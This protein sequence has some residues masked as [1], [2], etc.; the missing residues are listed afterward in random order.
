MYARLLEPP[1]GSFFLLGAR[2]TGK[3]TWLHGAFPEATRVDL[4]DEVRF[5][6][7]LADPAAFGRELAALPKGSRVVVDEIQRLPQLLNEVHRQIEARKHRFALTGSSARKLRRAGVNLLGG[8]AVHRTMHPLVP[9]ELGAD[10]DLERALRHGTLPIVWTADDP[11]DTLEAY[12]RLYLRE[13]IQN[14]ALVRNL[15]S[16]ARFLPFAALLHG[17]S[18]NVSNLA[19]DAGVART[20][21]VDYL[22]LLEDTL[23]ATRLEGFEAR[24]RVRERKHAKLYFVDPGVARALRGRLGK[25]SEEER[26]PLFEGMVYGI[27]R[28]YRGLGRLDAESITYWAPAD[29]Q[30]TEVDFLVSREGEHV[31]IE[32]KAS[33]VFRQEHT[34]GLRAI[35][36]LEGLRR[37]ILVYGGDSA[38]RTAEGIEVWPFTRFAEELDAGRLWDPEDP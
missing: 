22:S 32:V 10:F 7:Y 9:A 11:R 25:P 15:P 4:L 26:G 37:R 16:F 36:D 34:K 24:L 21:V 33:G 38:Q 19:R 35:A 5:Q 23:V 18:L 30:Q 12:A 2:G 29:A 8:R 3:T 28:A 20:T 31:A 1:K 13:E 17:Q 27:L 14:E 6:R